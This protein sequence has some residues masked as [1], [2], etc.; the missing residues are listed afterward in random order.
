[1]DRLKEFWWEKKVWKAL[2]LKAMLLDRGERKF[3]FH[4]P[5]LVN[6][7]IS[8]SIAKYYHCKMIRE[9][10]RPDK[11]IIITIVVRDAWLWK[12][13]L[14]RSARCEEGR[15]RSLPT[16]TTLDQSAHCVP[17]RFSMGHYN[18]PVWDATTTQY[19]ALP[20]N[21]EHHKQQV[22]DSKTHY[23]T[24]PLN[25]EHYNQPV[26]GATTNTTYFTHASFAM[27]PLSHPFPLAYK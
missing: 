17:P 7:L 18:Q 1:M 8:L 15:W 10:Q 13:L 23:G 21:M 24:L 16:R 12:Y 11:S 9:A 19:G 20:L 5:A 6:T 22:W 3:P 26:W 4:T 27:P 25:M 14:L 2:L